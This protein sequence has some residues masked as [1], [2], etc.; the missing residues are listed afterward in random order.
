[1][2]S[3][4]KHIP[5]APVIINGEEYGI[6]R[7]EFINGHRDVPSKTTETCLSDSMV[8]SFWRSAVQ[9]IRD[10]MRGSDDGELFTSEELDVFLGPWS[11]DIRHRVEAD[12]ERRYDVN[13][14]EYET[15]CTGVKESFEV[16]GAYD[17]DNDEN[18]PGLVC[19]LNSFYKN[20]QRE[21]FKIQ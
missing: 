12:V 6:Y 1:M 8:L 7:S 16:V 17:V 19:L 5:V 13:F 9:A 4:V 15:V 18:L 10:D 20:H 21:I 3:I 2:Q 11:I 14:G